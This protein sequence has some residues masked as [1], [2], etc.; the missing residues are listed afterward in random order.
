MIRFLDKQPARSA[1]SLF[2]MFMGV[3][4]A[5]LAAGVYLSFAA[6]LP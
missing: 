3:P 4:T 2:A 5:T 1:G 6:T